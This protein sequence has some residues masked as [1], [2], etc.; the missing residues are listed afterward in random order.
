M[1]HRRINESKSLANTLPWLTWVYVLSLVGVMLSPKPVP[2]STKPVLAVG[3]TTVHVPENAANGLADTLVFELSRPLE[4]RLEVPL[5][6]TD[7]SARNGEHF[8]VQRRPR[9]IFE[10]GSTTGTLSGDGDQCDVLIRDDLELRLG[11]PPTFEI[12][13]GTV[14]DIVQLD[15]N[16]STCRVAI[17][18]DEK[19]PKARVKI[20]FA[21]R[22]GELSES[23][24][25]ALSLTVQADAAPDE[26]SE[27]TV[28]VER[29]GAAGEAEL[30]RKV[31]FLEPGRNSL[32]FRVS[33]VVSASKLKDAGL[34]DDDAPG[35]PADL[36]VR[37]R[38]Q[39]PLY[40]DEPRDLMFRV[41]D[42]DPAAKLGM[43]IQDES[44]R[45]VDRVLPGTPFWVV[46]DVDRGIRLGTPLQVTLDKGS[47]TVTGTLAAGERSVRLGPL[48]ATPSSERMI[49]IT[50]EVPADAAT[51]SFVEPAVLTKRLRKGP[52]DAGRFAIIIVNTSRLREPG[53]GIMEAAW[54]YVD[55]AGSPPFGNGVLLVRP[56]RFTIL[57][58]AA[59]APDG[60][61]FSPL[62]KGGQGVAAQLKKLLEVAAYVRQESQ[63]PAIRIVVIWAERD[64]ESRAAISRLKPVDRQKFGPISFLCP[65]LG[66]DASGAL[67]AALVGGGDANVGG[68]TARCP[69]AVDLSEHIRWAIDGFQLPGKK[70]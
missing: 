30:G 11:E 42:N 57:A 7:G 29:H 38:G 47:P 61:W 13:L 44:G 35:P 9:V 36:V 23:Q 4:Y 22:G 53:N 65:D 28:V 17:D 70:K 27:M 60:E 10:A 46:A 66:A 24:V 63:D 6:V 20:R 69:D 12:T 39:H 31:F 43:S 37:L 54:N 58:N 16:R 18:D 45:Q 56:N 19:P 48:N 1:P 67:R 51:R 64:L 41:I 21:S 68:V 26:K 32:S 33:D 25:A 55:K 52:K 34:T 49:E 50:M 2:I 5:T 62:A 40:A 8:A 3:S 59:A 14:D 15:E